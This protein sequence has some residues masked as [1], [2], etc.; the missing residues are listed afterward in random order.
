[1]FIKFGTERPAHES[2]SAL[3]LLQL[4]AHGAECVSGDIR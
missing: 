4:D 3:V 1:V 2:S